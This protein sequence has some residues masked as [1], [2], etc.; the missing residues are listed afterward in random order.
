MRGHTPRIDGTDPSALCNVKQRLYIAA[1]A[2][3]EGLSS[4]AT[5]TVAEE[6]SVLTSA[7]SVDDGFSVN[8]MFESLKKRAKRIAKRMRR[9]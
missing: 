5:Y 8:P 7:T 3:L 9:K 6:A 1:A 2:S 4:R